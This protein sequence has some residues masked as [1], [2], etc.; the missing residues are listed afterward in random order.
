MTSHTGRVLGEDADDCYDSENPQSQAPARGAPRITSPL[1]P[2][3]YQS[4]G[5]SLVPIHKV[6]GV[7]NPAWSK[8]LSNLVRTPVSSRN[9]SPT[10]S[11]TTD[12][13]STMDDV[14]TNVCCLDQLKGL[15]P[16]C[17]SGDP[18]RPLQH[19]DENGVVSKYSLNPMIYSALFVLIVEGAYTMNIYIGARQS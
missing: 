15:P 7:D 11:S 1:I 14:P 10:T 12:G 9:G 3:A 2:R 16:E 8:T 13:S 18:K 4:H 17:L 19:F 5:E 6:D